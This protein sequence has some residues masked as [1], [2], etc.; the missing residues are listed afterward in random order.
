MLKA[1]IST[2]GRT[3]AQIPPE[4]EVG[5]GLDLSIAALLQE[6]ATGQRSGALRLRTADGRLSGVLNW[7]VGRVINA[8]WGPLRGDTAL[9]AV[10]QAR[11]L[12]YVWADVPTATHRD[13]QGELTT[14]LREEP[15]PVETEWARTEAGQPVSGTNPSTLATLQAEQ[16]FLLHHGRAI[17]DRFGLGEPSAGA[18]GEM[19]FNLAF[20]Q[21]G[22]TLHG[23]I[24]T[25][26]LAVGPLL[27]SVIRRREGE[28]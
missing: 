27:R 15:A 11:A 6:L 16:T 12:A 28:V 9:R 2:L 19:D 26:G 21:S 5:A 17:G 20:A 3:A 18:A 8:A 14:W 13:L 22:E 25:R 4:G 10:L 1:L 23:A 24:A 7:D